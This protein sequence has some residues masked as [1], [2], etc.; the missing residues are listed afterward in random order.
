[1]ISVY[2]TTLFVLAVTVVSAAIIL[3]AIWAII[4]NE[5]YTSLKEKAGHAHRAVVAWKVLPFTLIWPLA[6]PVAIVWLVS[7]IVRSLRSDLQGV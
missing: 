6:A 2:L 7:Q 1:M 4:R 5:D 3:T